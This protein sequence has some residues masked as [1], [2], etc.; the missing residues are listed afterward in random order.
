VSVTDPTT[1]SALRRNNVTVSGNLEGQPIV[2]AHGFGGSREAWRFVAPQFEA[3]YK[4]VTYDH[5]GAGGSDLSA[6]DR[7]KYDSL[8]GYADDVLEIIHELGLDDVIFV[9]HSVASMMG[10]LASIQR[11][12]VFS[13]LV[14]IGPSPRY[15][16]V[17][18]YVG[19]FTQADIDG[20]LESVDANYLTFADQVA[21][22]IMGRPEQPS[23]GAELT[24]SWKRV[25]PKI[26]AQFARVTFL[27]DNRKDLPLVTV[28]TLVVQMEEDIIAPHHVGKYVHDQIPGSSMAVIGT[29]GHVPN[30]SDPDDLVK[31]I[32]S[33]LP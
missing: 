14:L 9:G 3:D 22:A 17:D 15:V 19:G 26:G 5:V 4:V 8:H 16:S 2:F 29:R 24:D 1:A 6:Y 11:P 13:A 30:L 7:G 33:F 10:V 32:R 21:P 27:S 18:D 20:L 28:P 23:L 31:A 25:D 12:E